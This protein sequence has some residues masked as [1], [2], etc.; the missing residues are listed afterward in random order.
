MLYDKN[1]IACP[2]CH[3]FNIYFLKSGQGKCG[4][5]G[6]KFSIKKLQ[7]DKK[8]INS[9]CDNF[10]ALKCGKKY[11]LNYVTV[12]KRYMFLRE[13]I[14]GFLEG[15]FKNEYI[16]E[17]DE[18]IY[19][20]KSKKNQKKYIFD[21]IDFLTFN[22]KNKI[23]NLLLPTLKN[24]SDEF[25]NDGIETTCYKEFSK[26]MIFNKI[27]KIQ[28]KD[29]LIVKFWLYLEKEILKYK[30][31]KNE[32][33]FW[34]LKEIEFK[35]NYTKEEQLQIITDIIYRPPSLSQ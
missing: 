13:K 29:N 32:N 33:F 2:Y 5:C 24:Y 10:T 14:A 23:Y 19:L 4:K 20:E 26:F 12:K 27:S 22:Y 9:F 8:I 28:K 18:Y 25:I 3:S 16:I 7:R 6:K 30:G 1:N 34:Y 17:Y 11:D 15:N 21:A 31:I 35:F